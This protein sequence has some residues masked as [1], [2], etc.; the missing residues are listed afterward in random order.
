MRDAVL[1]GLWWLDAPADNAA[2]EYQAPTVEPPKRKRRWFQYS[3]R[4]LLIFTLIVAVACGWLASKV[5]R[6]RSERAA[7]EA[8]RKKGATVTYDYDRV[9][10]RTPYGPAWMRWLLG[11][12][13]FSEVQWVA[14][15][16]NVDADDLN[17]VAQFPHLTSLT[18]MSR[19]FTDAGLANLTGLRELRDLNL[20]QASLTDDGL[21]D[22]AGFTQLETL[23]L[24]GTKVTDA[25]L[26][27]LRGL[28]RLKYLSL[29]F[30]NVSDGPVAELQKALP[31]C[32]IDH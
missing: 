7:V 8:L 32:H 29:A 3:L 19:G 4:T 12:N 27:H 2:M 13:Y 24:Y 17:A 5:E 25:G 28:T 20:S 9:R 1:I 10:S 16:G 15:G 21:K 11:E 30:T 23:W 26:V 6:K 18:M 14:M 22:L 31:N